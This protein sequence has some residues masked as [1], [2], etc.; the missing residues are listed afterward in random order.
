M[1][2]EKSHDQGGDDEEELHRL[3]RREK[4]V[5]KIGRVKN[6]TIPQI[7][8]NTHLKKQRASHVKD[9]SIFVLDNSIMLRRARVTCLM[10]NV[11]CLVV[12]F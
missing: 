5:D 11:T 8:R 2:E 4:T 10:K 3:G 12:L 6:D 1:K 9:M 7:A